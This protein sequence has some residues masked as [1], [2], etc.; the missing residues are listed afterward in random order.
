M[1]SSLRARLAVFALVI[2]MGLVLAVPSAQAAPEFGIEKFFAANCKEGFETCE[3][4][5]KPEEEVKLAEEQGFSQAAGHP[6]FGVTDFTVAN[7]EVALGQKEPN[8]IVRHIRVDV[9]PGLSTNP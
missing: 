2:G 5:A 1:S 6:N 7:H 4:A 3:A 8:G 9:A